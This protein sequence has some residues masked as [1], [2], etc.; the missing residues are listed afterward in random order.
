MNCIKDVANKK[1]VVEERVGFRM[2]VDGI[3]RFAR[4]AKLY[5]SECYAKADNGRFPAGTYEE[6]Q[7][8]FKENPQWEAEKRA[9]LNERR[10]SSLI[11]DDTSNYVPEFTAISAELAAYLHDFTYVLEDMCKVVNDVF[12]KMNVV[13]CVEYTSEGI[14]FNPED[15]VRLRKLFPKIKD[16]KYLILDGNTF[17][18]VAE[19]C[20]YL[21][22]EKKDEICLKDERIKDLAKRY[23]KKKTLGLV[24]D[25][26]TIN[27]VEDDYMKCVCVL[28]LIFLTIKKN[29]DTWDKPERRAYFMMSVRLINGVLYHF[30]KDEPN[31]TVGTYIQKLYTAK[32][33]LLPRDKDFNKGFKDSEKYDETTLISLFSPDASKKMLETQCIRQPQFKQIIGAVMSSH[34]KVNECDLNQGI[35]EMKITYDYMMKF[36]EESAEIKTNRDRISFLDAAVKNNFNTTKE[37]KE[38][39]TYLR[40]TSNLKEY[41][42]KLDN[43]M[44]TFKDDLRAEVHTR[45]VAEL[46]KSNTFAKNVESL[47]MNEDGQLN[48]AELEIFFQ[49]IITGD[50]KF[51]KMFKKK[52]IEAIKP[53]IESGLKLEIKRD[54]LK[55]LEL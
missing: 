19:I 14:G 12:K 3:N 46:K 55:A 54:M 17:M 43:L 53:E 11:L 2:G 26:N 10:T 21:V 27:L 22:Y 48:E 30:H 8:A 9:S 41:S 18:A 7:R 13:P 23:N 16:K 35:L 34:R 6:L 52:M 33:V 20:D 45:T 4:L 44:N 38:L 31:L 25:M 24:Y 47:C 15:F 36:Q 49:N 5:A 50:S 29:V 42:E 32:S 37:L 1:N 51:S 28:L 40:S 39:K